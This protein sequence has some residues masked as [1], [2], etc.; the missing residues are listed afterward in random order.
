MIP[1][2]PCHHFVLLLGKRHVSRQGKL[3]PTPAIPGGYGRNHPSVRFRRFPGGGSG[4]AAHLQAL[5]QHQQRILL[6]D[7]GHGY[8]REEEAA[9]LSANSSWLLRQL[10][11]H[12]A[13]DAC[14]DVGGDPDHVGPA[15]L[16][17]QVVRARLSYL[18]I[19]NGSSMAFKYLKRKSR[20]PWNNLPVHSSGDLYPYL[21]EKLP[22]FHRDLP[23]S[24]TL[25]SDIE[26]EESDIVS[27]LDELPSQLEQEFHIRNARRQRFTNLDVLCEG[28]TRAIL[29]GHRQVQPW[30]LYFS[31]EGGL[32]VLALDTYREDSPWGIVPCSS[33]PN[34]GVAWRKTQGGD[35]QIWLATARKKGQDWD[36]DSDIGH[37]SAHSSFAPIPLFAQALHLDS[38]I[39]SLNTVKNIQ[40][41]SANHLARMIYTYSE[42]AVIAVRG[43]QRETETGLPVVERPEELYAFLDLSHQLM[44]D[45]GFNRA[46]SACQRISGRIDVIDSVEIFKI[47]APVM[48]VLPYIARLAKHFSVPTINCYRSMLN[49]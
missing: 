17:G 30:A 42:V 25:Y 19:Q 49:S 7:F 10:A 31:K 32:D 38:E 21:S 39:T 4:G 26:V 1:D 15:S 46:L 22:N 23:A 43:E 36:W 35:C 18:A 8:L 33:M 12:Q 27:F 13:G 14:G 37:E 3:V 44:P 5:R 9:L 2:L 6:R 16:R 48:R 40:E 20:L 24:V 41:L 45:L 29:T 47:G 11:A 34:H 28:E